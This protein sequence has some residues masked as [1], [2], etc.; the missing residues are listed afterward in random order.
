MFNYINDY[1]QLGTFQ[2]ALKE[3]QTVSLDTE[4]TG[5]NPFSDDL[6]LIQIKLNGETF[7][8]DCTLL[9]N[10]YVTYVVQLI[11]DSNVKVIGHNIKF[12]MK[13][14]AQKT[15]E[16]LIN[17]FDTFTAEI[18][19]TNGISVGKD[20]FPTLKDLVKKYCDVEL[21]KDMQKEFINSHEITNEKL[22]YASLDVEYL[23]DI[24]KIQK[25]EIEKSRQTKV[26]DLEMRVLPAVISMELNG[27]TLDL[28]RWQEL[29]EIAEANAKRLSK[30][31][32][33]EIFSRIDLSRFKNMQEAY[34]ALSI[35]LPN[36]KQEREK[37]LG[38]AYPTFYKDRIM[39]DF[40]VGSTYQMQSALRLLGYT[41]VTSTNADYL[42]GLNLNDSIIDKIIEFREENK[43]ATA[44]G[45]KF[46]KNIEPT[47]GKIHS[48]FN[49]MG[50]RSGRFSSSDPNL[51]NIISDQAYRSCF[52]ASPGKVIIGGDFSQEEYRL[53]GAVSGEPEI[54][55]AYKAGYDMHTKTASIVN[56]IPIEKVT[57]ELRQKAK[58][59]NFSILYGTTEYGM[60]IKQKMSTDEANR[61]I[62]T[63]YRGYPTLNR[64]QSMMKKKI[65]E[66]GYAL[67]LLG[68]RRYFV[69]K[70]FYEGNDAYKQKRKFDEST[71][72]EGFNH[73]IQGTG[74][75]VI[76]EALSRLYFENPFGK[77]FALLLTVHDEIE[78]EADEDIKEEAEKF[79]VKVMTSTL[80]KYLGEIPAVVESYVETYW[81]H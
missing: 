25:E 62:E 80:Q 36:T 78:C 75:D 8:F 55:E 7:I 76:K 51:Q 10:K 14:L 68:R 50:A 2:Q 54:I 1:H 81:K 49:A 13:F 52:I 63:F 61:I 64:Y 46:A 60:A 12:D 59:I 42:V 45:E 57:K 30:E 22:I 34:K 79:L 67:T 19:I 18:I 58:T 38:I 40:N 43:K 3:S 72:R 71:Q 31:I 20:R 69:D 9:E 56:N 26:F 29:S 47:T 37:M 21:S 17:V 70:V 5:L 33:E 23:E 24:Y 41:Q 4:T 73:I 28:K 16:M 77:K 39:N 65:L 53:A 6:L 27:I 74:G 48:E 11:K 35:P 66:K 15:G 44:S 32:V